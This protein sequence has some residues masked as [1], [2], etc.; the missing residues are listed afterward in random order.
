[1]PLYAL[2][3][4]KWL[5]RLQIATGRR[6]VNGRI[7]YKDVQRTFD[8]KSAGEAWEKQQLDQQG[9][10]GTKGTL[11]VSEVAEYREAKKLV[12]GND[13]RDA[14]H[15]WAD[16]NPEAEQITVAK[17][18]DEYMSS[19]EWERLAETTKGSE[20]LGS[21][22]WGCRVFAGNWRTDCI[23]RQWIG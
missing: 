17:A 23:A 9:R 7:Q 19:R 12:R 1:M 15:F 14:A 10:T 13:L 6:D 3:N 16:R 22:T 11:N 20:R 5:C 4:G 18:I 21:A 8:T 2:K